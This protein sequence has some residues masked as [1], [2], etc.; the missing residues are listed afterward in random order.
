MALSFLLLLSLFCRAAGMDIRQFVAHLP[1]NDTLTVYDGKN[2]AGSM[3]CRFFT[4]ESNIYNEIQFSISMP[5]PIGCGTVRMQLDETRKY[6]SCGAL[7]EAFQKIC[8]EAGKN[9]WHLTRNSGIWNITVITA[10][11]RNTIPV[12]RVH[13]HIRTTAD[14]YNGIISNSLREGTSW[15]DTVA[16]LTS[17]SA[18]VSVIKVLQGPDPANGNCWIFSCLNE[19]TQKTEYWKVNRKGQTVYREIYP[20]V[21][22][23]S[24][25]FPMDKNSEDNYHSLAVVSAPVKARQS[26]ESF[27][28]LFLD[29]RDV[30]STVRFLYEMKDSVFVLKSTMQQCRKGGNPLSTVERKTGTAPTPTLQINHYKIKKL[31]TSLYN[32][33]LSVCKNIKRFNDYLYVNLKKKGSATFSSALETLTSGYGDC[34][35]HA[36]LL[37]ALLRS[38]E[39]PAH[40]IL[41][42]VYN[43]LKNCFLY[44]AWVMVYTG[45]EWIFADPSHGEFPAWNN[46]IPL[47]ID[48]DGTHLLS[49]AT[50]LGNIRVFYMKN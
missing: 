24:G 21:A 20:Y 31:A 6:D 40:V 8:S 12:R 9:S 33:S 10:G 39:I 29:K 19:I 32:D 2:L 50:I 16:E 44:H 22:A 4:K 48:D 49:F 41:G 3:V 5:D 15:R 47:M 37:A 27:G 23:K 26:D 34:S 13:D 30:D 36:V 35:E 45:G 38:R 7:V 25:S 11:V 43:R 28:I 46:R 1:V 14:I 18:V 42:L 17:G